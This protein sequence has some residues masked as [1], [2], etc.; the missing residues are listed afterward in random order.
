MRNKR[1]ISGPLMREGLKQ[2]W[3]IPVLIFIAYFMS[4]IFPLIL[5]GLGYDAG[6]FARECLVNNNLG[7]LFLIGLASIVTGCIATRMWH[8]QAQAFSVI[9]QP[10][11]RTRLFNSNLLLGWLMMIAPIILMA[12]IYL[13]LSPVVRTVPPGSDLLYGPM[14]D[15]VATVPAY[16]VSDVACWLLE[17]T[18]MFTFLY[19][20]SVTAGVFSGTTMMTVLLSLFNM[21]IVCV[22]VGTGMLYAEEYLRGFYGM[23]DL[24]RTLISI[25]NPILGKMISLINN[26]QPLL[27]TVPRSLLYILAG[28]IIL[29]LARAAFGRAKLERTGDHMMS[30]RGEALVTAI[31]TFEGAALLGFMMG[32][33][34]ESGPAMA[35]GF[36]LGAVI[37]WFIVKVILVRTVKIF[38]KEHI[39]PLIAGTICAAVFV[40]V[41]LADIFGYGLRVPDKSDIKSVD[42]SSLYYDNAI[43]LYDE[44]TGVIGTDRNIEDEEF[45]SKVVDL[46]RYIVDSGLVSKNNTGDLSITFSYEL[47]NGRSME[48]RIFLPADD[49]AIEML[50]DI[51]DTKVYRDRWLLPEEVITSAKRAEVT[52]NISDAGQ[53]S[54]SLQYD[55]YLSITDKDTLQDLLDA[56]AATVRDHRTDVKGWIQGRDDIPEGRM[57]WI[58]I[59][60]TYEDG[61]PGEAGDGFIEIMINESSSELEGF[62]IKL[63][64]EEK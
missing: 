48:R 14:L 41:F 60:L 42:P 26:E 19:A 50:Q 36:V 52:C 9:S 62:V 23:G 56:Y 31:L 43:V 20:L 1:W 63:H 29:L 40:M 57:C 33:G 18:A 46:H 15:D 16:G 30:R 3:F 21:G 12:V 35:V 58:D 6:N 7:F 8:G 11:S 28:V 39:M 53:N 44:G 17:T 51:V 34:F 2:F 22:T 32:M 27:G 45:I 25:S 64:D 61:A 54:N 55:F 38:S 47:K 5:R 4:G 37:T 59:G 13:V 49:K 10:Y 24:P